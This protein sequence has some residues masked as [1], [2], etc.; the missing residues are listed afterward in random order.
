M[1]A[2]PAWAAA[3]CIE[4]KADCERWVTLGGGPARSLI[5]STYPLDARNASITRALIVV[6]GQ[7]RNAD[8]YFRTAVAAAFLGDALADTIVIA[9]RF[10]ASNGTCKDALAANEVNWTCTGVSWRAGG[11]A[12]GNE[13]LTS[14]DLADEILRK[15]AR[16]DV[17]PNLKLIVFSGHS[18]GGQFVSRYELTNQVHEK[19]GMP[20]TYV[21]A[22]PSSYAWP[23]ANRPVADKA[24]YGP[25]RDSACAYDRWPYGWQQ[26]VGYAARVTDDQLRK[27]LASR[28]VVY[29][30]G[31]LDTLPIAGFDSTCPAMAQGQ[32]RLARGQAYT[33]YLKDQ[34]NVPLTFMTIPACGHNARCMF[35]AERALPVLF[36]KP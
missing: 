28:P 10:A 15:L 17:F 3:P 9:P 16:K 34:Y 30:V 29:M 27:Q 13:A 25:Y 12:V 33:T 14:F 1:S 23:D 18:A 4:A 35:T 11:V 36:P 26:R 6:H 20:V 2:G 21:V 8:G 31:A 19:L 24:E 32:N 5:Y 7:G 22:N